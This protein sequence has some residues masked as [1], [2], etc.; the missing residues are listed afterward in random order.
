MLLSEGWSQKQSFYKFCGNNWLSTAA[1]FRIPCYQKANVKKYALLKES[2]HFATEFYF[3]GFQMATSI[4]KEK[5]GVQHL[6]LWK[7]NHLTL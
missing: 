6:Q 7:A 2:L 3:K 4:E 5:K 1:R